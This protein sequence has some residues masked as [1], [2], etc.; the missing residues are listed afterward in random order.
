MKYTYL[1][2]N[3]LSVLFPFIFSFHPKLNYYKKFKFLFPAML[4]TAIGFI[5]WDI[6]FTQW[7]VWGFNP[8]YLT[9]IY[10]FNLPIEEVLF[11]IC[12]PFSSIFIHEA[13]KA[14]NI[15]DYFINY[16]KRIT[17]TLITVSVLM[18]VFFHDKYYTC[19]TFALNAAFLIIHPLFKIK[20]LSRFYF[21][22]LIILIPFFI[23]NGLLTGTGLEEPIVWYNNDENLGIRMLTIP[24]EDAFYGMLMLLLSVSLMEIFEREKSSKKDLLQYPTS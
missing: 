20:S 19:T 11:F 8:K 21:A 14:Y 18:A 5:A 22:Y 10:F 13:L 3:L 2:I 16:E 24:I 23:V 1:L 4:I 7:G 15:K 17:G 6:L 12:I 9:G